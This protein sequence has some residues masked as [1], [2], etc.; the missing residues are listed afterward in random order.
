MTTAT[1]EVFYMGHLVLADEYSFA[2]SEE[3]VREDLDL[4][5][6]RGFITDWDEGRLYVGGPDACNG[7]PS[8]IVTKEVP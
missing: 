4:A 7:E 5:A 1:I 8:F 3:D 6:M 2:P